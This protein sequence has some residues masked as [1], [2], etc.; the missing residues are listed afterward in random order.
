MAWALS[1]G[2]VTFFAAAIAQGQSTR[3]LD[4]VDVMAI[5][6]FEDKRPTRLTIPWARDLPPFWRPF[7]KRY[8]ATLT[9]T[10]VVFGF[11]MCLYRY[12]MSVHCDIFEW[13]I[14]LPAVP[15]T[16]LLCF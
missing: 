9:Q 11:V 15:F 1:Y 4:T 14:C 8:A 7:S 12:E 2:F 6:D 3:K 13:N 5:F 10:R 16:K